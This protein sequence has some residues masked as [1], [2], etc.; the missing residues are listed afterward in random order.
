LIADFALSSFEDR[1]F[2]RI[3]HLASPVGSLGILSKSGCVAKQI[4]DLAVR[5][6]ELAAASGAALLYVSSSE[7][8]GKA[9]EQCEHDELSVPVETGTRMEYALGKLTGEHLLRNLALRF[10][11]RLT[12]ARPFNALGENQSSRIGFVVPTFFEQ[13]IAGRPLSLFHGG[14]QVRCFCHVNDMVRGFVAV[15]EH[16]VEGGAYNLGHPGNA[17]SI[18]NLAL[19]IRALCRSK[20]PLETVD[21]VQL[22]GTHYLEASA[23]SPCIR[24]AQGDTGWTPIIDLDT[25]LRWIH[26]HYLDSDTAPHACHPHRVAAA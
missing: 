15:Q 26:R 18:R 4:T 7:T 25:A 5:A 8:Y 12:V 13:A 1:A 3:Y 9:G 23:K 16:G 6:G 2:D 19:K 17:I 14:S 24:K 22:F 21:P 20:S 10:G 11:F